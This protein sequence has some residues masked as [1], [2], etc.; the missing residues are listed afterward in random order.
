MYIQMYTYTGTSITTNINM[1]AYLMFVF[2]YNYYESFRLHSACSFHMYVH[3]YLPA[4]NTHIHTY[5][6]LHVCMFMHTF[7]SLTFFFA[8]LVVAIRNK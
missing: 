5:I 7:H 8:F 4:S 6:K 3:T 2:T 1:C